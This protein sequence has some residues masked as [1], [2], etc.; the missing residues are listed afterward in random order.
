M[1]SQECLAF[2]KHARNTIT[3]IEIFSDVLGQKRLYKQM[4]QFTEKQ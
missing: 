1:L 2:S 4:L 3:K